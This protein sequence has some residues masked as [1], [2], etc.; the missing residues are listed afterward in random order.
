MAPMGQDGD[1]DTTLD[2][3]VYGAIRSTSGGQPNEFTFAGEQVSGCRL[4]RRYAV[5]RRYDD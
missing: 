1:V 5:P 2:Y 3:D 4:R